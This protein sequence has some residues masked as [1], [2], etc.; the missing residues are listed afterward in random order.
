MKLRLH[1]SRKSFLRTAI[2]IAAL[3]VIYII[4][5]KHTATK[6]DYSVGR[7]WNYDPITTSIDVPVFND[8]ERQKQIEDSLKSNF[9]PIYR[10]NNEIAEKVTEEY[11]NE[12]AESPDLNLSA[13]GRNRLVNTLAQIYEIGI[14]DSRGGAAP[15]A[16][17][18]H[19]DPDSVSDPVPAAS[20][21]TFAS[22]HG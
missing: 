20:F 19:I 1:I 22:A 5:P 15:K 18:L 13:A 12:L 14:Y 3:V 16:I 8:A 4:I 9:K 17:R 7:L 11:R 2:F 10:R 6:Y 21:Y